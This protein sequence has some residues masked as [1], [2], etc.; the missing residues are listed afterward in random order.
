LDQ[1]QEIKYLGI[2]FESKLNFNAHID[3]SMVKLINLIN[4]SD[5]RA[6]LQWGLGHKAVKQYTKE[7][8]S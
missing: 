4:M 5:R 7:Q 1:I 6:K 3:H 2:Y 8:F